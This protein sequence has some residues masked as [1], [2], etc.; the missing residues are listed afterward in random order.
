MIL[1]VDMKPIPLAGR[2][3]LSVLIAKYSFSLRD[4]LAF[5]SKIGSSIVYEFEITDLKRWIFQE[6]SNQISDV[7]NFLAAFNKFQNYLALQMNRTEYLSELV[8][9][10]NMAQHCTVGH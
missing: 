1:I 6:K 10:D 8:C 7:F 2:P 5:R 9:S 4:V 3:V